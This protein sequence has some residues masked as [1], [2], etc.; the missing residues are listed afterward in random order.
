MGPLSTSPLIFLG[1]VYATGQHSVLYQ[2]TSVPRETFSNL[3]KSLVITEDGLKQC[4][5]ICSIKNAICNI[6][7]F[8]KSDHSCTFGKIFCREG[9]DIANSQEMYLVPEVNRDCGGWGAWSS[10]RCGGD[11]KIGRTRTCES[12]S[13]AWDGTECQEGVEDSSGSGEDCE[14]GLCPG[15]GEWGPWGVCDTKCRRYRTRE[16]LGRCSGDDKDMDMEWICNENTCSGKSYDKLWS[17]SQCAYMGH[18][19]KYSIEDCKTACKKKSGCTA[20]NFCGGCHLR[21]C[22]VPAPVPTSSHPGCEGLG[23]GHTMGG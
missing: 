16:C 14:G 15:W 22:N 20:F 4:G 5:Y 21:G 10:L 18:I 2:K 11:C 6:F 1:I 23:E 17:D 8:D 9:Q 3:N 12:S 19:N 7:R 13:P